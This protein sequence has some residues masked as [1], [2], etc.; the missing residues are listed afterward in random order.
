MSS[1]VTV[2]EDMRREG[3]TLTIRAEPVLAVQEL[4]RESGEEIP[5]V[6]LT[7]LVDTGASGTLVQSAVFS[8]VGIE[9]FSFAY[10]RTPSTNEPILCGR[11]RV[12]IVLS[13]VLA[14]EVDA[15]NGALTGQNLQCLI[16][17]DILQDVQL[18]YDGP[19]NQFTITQP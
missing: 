13:E 8:Q 3:P 17:R 4:L 16:G 14:F 6:T 18:A 2:V 5:S 11:H 9:P 12:R 1:L 7:A 19:R 10:L 15:V